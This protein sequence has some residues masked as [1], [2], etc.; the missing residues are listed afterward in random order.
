MQT[1][2]ELGI[3]CMVGKCSNHSATKS[4]YQNSKKHKFLYYKREKLQFTINA[5]RLWKSML[6]ISLHCIFDVLKGSRVYFTKNE[7]VYPPQR[8]L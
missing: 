5:F 2:I 6:N 4:S 1:G 8:A 7:L 3:P